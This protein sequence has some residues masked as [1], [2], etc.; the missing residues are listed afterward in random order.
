MV[1]TAGNLENLLWTPCRTGLRKVIVF[2]FFLPDF[3]ALWEGKE[4]LVDSNDSDQN[5]CRLCFPVVVGRFV[6]S[7]KDCS[8]MQ[9]VCVSRAKGLKL[10]RVY[11]WFSKCGAVSRRRNGLRGSI[12]SASSWVGYLL[13]F[14]SARLVAFLSCHFFFPMGEIVCRG[15]FVQQMNAIRDYF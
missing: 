14:L 15:I 11:N 12:F 8:L 4:R 9:D 10:S 5:H 1:T 6:A 2:F 7:L 13:Q 3:L